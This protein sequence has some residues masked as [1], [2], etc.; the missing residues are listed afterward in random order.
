LKKARLRAFF[1]SFA[2]APS[3]ASAVTGVRRRGWR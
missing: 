2:K 1:F 3:S